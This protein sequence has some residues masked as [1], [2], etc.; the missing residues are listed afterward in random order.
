MWDS[1]ALCWTQSLITRLIK[2]W[3]VGCCAAN[4]PLCSGPCP[5]NWFHL[6]GDHVLID[7]C[8]TSPEKNKKTRDGLLSRNQSVILQQQPSL[9]PPVAP[10]SREDSGPDPPKKRAKDSL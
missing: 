3:V 4:R 1:T 10:T 5:E 6:R 7:G 9:I 2:S 8:T